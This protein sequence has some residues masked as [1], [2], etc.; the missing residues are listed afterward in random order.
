LLHLNR[1]VFCA[2]QSPP[3]LNARILIPTPIFEF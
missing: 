1:S 3:L 2:A